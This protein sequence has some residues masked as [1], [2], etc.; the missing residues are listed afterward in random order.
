[1]FPEIDYAFYRDTYGGIAIASEEEFAG[2]RMLAN[3]FV[4]TAS[5]GKYMGAE[6]WMSEA[7]LTVVKYAVCALCDYD[8]AEEMRKS[9]NQVSSESVGGHSRSYNIQNRDESVIYND[10]MRLLSGYLLGT[11]LLYRGVL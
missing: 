1:M 2:Y 3:S 6:E 8:K 10:K 11:G 5:A 9:A 7:Q 4:N